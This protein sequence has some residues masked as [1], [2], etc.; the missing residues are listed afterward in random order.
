MI[1]NYIKYEIVSDK[2]DLKCLWPIYGKPQNKTLLRKIKE[3]IK[4]EM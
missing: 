4:W 2:S 3:E 1:C